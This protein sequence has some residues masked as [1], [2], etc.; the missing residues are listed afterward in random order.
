M[1]V[2][3]TRAWVEVDLGALRRNAAKMAARG[4]PLVPMVK[5]EAYGLGALAV[6]RALEPMAPWGY[7]VATV[8]EGIALR[9]GGV[10]RRIL[11]FTPIRGGDA[12]AARE[13]GLTPVFGCP[14]DIA[15]WRE[16]GGGAWHLAIDTG[17]SRVGVRWDEIERV[18][19]AVAAAQ[20]E[21]AYTH[22]YS[23]ERADG[24]A[25]EQERRFEETIAR[26]PARPPLLHVENSAA[27]ARVAR[28]RWD[29]ARPGMFLYGVGSGPGV[30]VEP[31]PVVQV[32]ARV[33]DLR[34]LH[35]GDT[36]SYGAT[37]RADGP[38]RIATLAIG[39]A[40]G[41]RRALGM[42][43]V[44]LLRGRRV[45]VVGLVTMD[46][47]MI[48]VTGVECEMGDVATLIGADGSE[49]HH[50]G[51]VARLADVSPYEV[52]TGLGARLGR[53]YIGGGE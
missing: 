4:A 6:V 46:M 23:P 25:R 22:F 10:S 33:V 50:V 2:E 45:P 17:M 18:Q 24:S 12:R 36:V 53:R 52:L 16:G 29:L 40:D 11:L 19:R 42:H 43:G 44:V 38:R 9:E 5:A 49:Q 28:S 51:D 39:Y 37:Y 14:E 3:L 31:E 34:T 26:L 20:P 41:Y 48:D 30:L 47:T 35:A 8:G 15:R 21:G 1:R 13:A 27:L 32:R 7:G